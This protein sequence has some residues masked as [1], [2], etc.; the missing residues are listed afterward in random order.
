MNRRA[1]S[2]SISVCLPLALLAGTCLAQN[3]ER[4]SLTSTG[5]ATTTSSSTCKVTPGG[6]F[7]VFT[8]AAALLPDDTNGRVDVYV[9]DRYL[10]TVARISLPDPSLGGEGNNTCNLTN[11]SGRVIS[12]DGRFVIF[13]SDSD[14]LVSNDTNGV[15]DVFVRDRDRDGNGVFDEPGAGKTRTTR[16]SLSSNEGQGVGPC[17]NQI[18][19]H[20]SEHG[21]ISASGRYVA[22]QSQYNF[23][24]GGEP[25]MNVYWRDRD[26]DNDGLFDEA[27]GTPD[28]AVTKVVS[29]RIGT[30]FHG[31]QGDGFSQNPAIS[32]DGRWVV[33]ESVSR[34]MV[35]SDNTSNQE[36]FA[37]DMF[38]DTQNIRITE[39]LA[40]G[41]PDSN[42]S[43]AVVSG[44]GRFVAFVTGADNL[45]AGVNEN[46]ANVVLKDRDTDNDG[47]LDEAGAVSFLNASIGR[48]IFVIPNNVVALNDSSSR[49]SISDDGRYV[50]FDSAATNFSCALACADTN[51]MVD[52]FVYDRMS[53]ATSRASISRLNAQVSGTSDF[54]T[55]SPDGRFIGF[56]SNATGLDGT[57]STAFDNVYVRALQPY[58]LNTQCATPIAISTG[59]T[60]GDTWAAPASGET[61]CAAAGNTNGTSSVWFSYLA[62]C[63]GQVTMNTAGAS[64]DTVLSAYSAPC[65]ATADKQI[66]CN[67]DVA[68]GIL[69]SE[70]TLSVTQGQTY[71][72]RVGGYDFDSGYF[73]LN[74]GAIV[75]APS[76]AADFNMD[77]NLDP[78]DLGDYINCYFGVPPCGQADFNNDGN[79][80]PDDLGDY[81]NA[82][83]TG[84]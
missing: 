62:S 45:A 31:Q 80:D 16:V 76:C 6:R 18:C 52:V 26:A 38:V 20:Y 72:I 48:N 35:F 5:S 3:T 78:D 82:Y 29:K 1:I 41:Q 19:D 7:A 28:A 44:N 66:A 77:G 25:F 42:S 67:D 23:T 70:I 59:V 46:A 58:G 55:I 73:R 22:W 79:V 34:Y 50:A 47:I 24:S 56:A 74:V 84:C 11:G 36:I 15:G 60:A 81:I 69:H 65:P 75:C 17:P 8:T 71:L 21:V 53:V 61:T 39:P 9:R 40:G 49:P 14:N 4:V 54:A 32:A 43:N 13:N 37:R 83:F 57:V 12:D 2:S 33:F 30:Q 27:G 68:T 10:N 51:G 63:T 64:Y